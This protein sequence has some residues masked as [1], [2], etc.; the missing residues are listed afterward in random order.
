MSVTL[1]LDL[2]DTLLG[3]DINTFLPEYMGSFARFVSGLV[4]PADF[5]HA[6]R[7]GTEA[8]I[9]NRQPDC[10]LQKAFEGAFF[11]RL[12]VDPVEFYQ[13][14]DRFYQ[15]IFPNLRRL[16]DA[17]SGA[18]ELVDKAI[19]RRDRLAVTTNPLFPR[20]ANLQRLSW[21]GLAADSRVFEVIGS[22]EKF[23]FAKPDPAF[24]AEALA[25]MGWPAGPVIVVGDDLERDVRAGS[26][27]GLKTY[28]LNTT[29]AVLT[30]GAVPPSA[31]GDHAGVYRW[32]DTA[33]AEN[34]EPDYSTPD[35]CL[36]VLRSTPAALDT[37]TRDLPAQVWKLAPGAGEWSLTEIACHLRDVEA[38]V[39]LVRLQKLLETH[40]PF[41]A[42]QDTDRWA[43]ERDYTRTD[44]RGAMREFFQ[45]RMEVVRILEGLSADDW[46]RP[47]RHAIFGPTRL[48]ELVGIMAAHDRLHIRQVMS[49]LAFD[50]E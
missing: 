9:A 14:A 28:W 8:M 1:L 44:G 20:V 5:L 47:A 11:S 35:A 10:T 23:H 13:Y 45:S 49:V 31:Q 32:I 50:L 12:K 34:L 24:Y 2:D 19:D 42:G 7:L 15:E 26:R 6:M 17:W 43:E 4:N 29:G 38:E 3:N 33:A 41:L 27:L 18:V 37:L 48:I 25:Y 30:N 36:A 40:N 16:T 22:F 21:A 46:Q 39:S